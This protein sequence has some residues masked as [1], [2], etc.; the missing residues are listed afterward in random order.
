MTSVP[1]LDLSSA[2]DTD[3]PHTAGRGGEEG[4]RAQGV[5]GAGPPSLTDGVPGLPI[6]RI[7]HHL[8]Y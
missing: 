6:F 4:P 8:T 5:G 2:V 3:P 1:P 7:F